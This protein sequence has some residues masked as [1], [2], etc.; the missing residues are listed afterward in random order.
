[1]VVRS[2]TTDGRSASQCQGNGQI[3]PSTT[4][5]AAGGEG[6]RCTLR[7][8]LQREPKKFQHSLQFGSHPV[9]REDL[10]VP[11]EAAELEQLSGNQR[12]RRL[13]E[14]DWAVCAQGMRLTSTYSPLIRR[15]MVTFVFP[16]FRQYQPWLPSNAASR[17][18]SSPATALAFL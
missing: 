14:N 11:G 4:L 16:R 3:S 8:E 17:T 9:F 7:M 5:Q 12:R 15:A 18:P 6:G 13:D 10:S 1:M 2:R